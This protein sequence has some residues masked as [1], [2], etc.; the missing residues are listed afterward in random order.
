MQF[1]KLIFL[2]SFFATLLACSNDKKSSTEN[3]KSTNVGEP[4]QPVIDTGKVEITLSNGKEKQ[5]SFCR[6]AYFKL[7]DSSFVYEE[8]VNKKILE[9]LSYYFDEKE[10]AKLSPKLN[11]EFFKEILSLYK[12]MYEENKFDDILWGVDEFFDIDNSY[13]EFV[14]LTRAAYDYSGGAHGNYLNNNYLFSKETGEQLHL[15][16]VIN[17]F[18]KFK[19]LAEKNFRIQNEIPPKVSLEDYG[20]WFEKEFE[21]SQ[22]FYFSEKGMEFVYNPY[23][24]GPYALGQI[25][26]TI[27]KKDI[28]PFLKIN[29]ERTK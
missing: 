6:Y 26:F 2:F 21:P 19:V 28:L 27:S 20:F 10:R 4:Y 24:I 15:A 3:L 14:Y 23:E 9:E 5:I 12:E 1:K 8:M 18:S 29:I 25:T 22:N 7:N 17:D 13:K 11:V 16:D